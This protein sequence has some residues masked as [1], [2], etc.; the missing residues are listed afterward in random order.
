[1][2]RWIRNYSITRLSN[3]PHSGKVIT[4]FM[5]VITQT[6]KK[7]VL[8]PQASHLPNVVNVSVDFQKHLVNLKVCLQPLRA[9]EFLYC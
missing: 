7:N 8:T 5:S 2:M 9:S 4:P 3:P 1:M 6:G